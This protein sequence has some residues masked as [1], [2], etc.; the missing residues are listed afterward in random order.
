M[1]ADLRL[2]EWKKQ[3]C[4]IEGEGIIVE[5]TTQT[6][7]HG[8]FME[9]E[10]ILNGTTN[11]V[12]QVVIRPLIR[13]KCWVGARA[14]NKFF[15]ASFDL[16]NGST[17][18]AGE[19]VT[20]HSIINNEDGTFE[21]RVLFEGNFPVENPAFG[22]GALLS[23]QAEDYDGQAGVQAI[24]VLAFHF[25]E[26]TAFLPNLG[27]NQ[28][29]DVF[30]FVRTG[31]APLVLSN[32][33]YET[34]AFT[35]S[36][37]IKKAA[38]TD[39]ETTLLQHWRE[40]D[41][42]RAWRL[43]LNASGHPSIALSDDGASIVKH[44]ASKIPLPADE[45]CLISFSWSGDKLR[46]FIN[47]IELEQDQ[48]QSIV[49]L[50]FE[51]K[52]HASAAPVEAI[53]SENGASF[54][55]WL[56]SDLREP[57]A[58]AS[59]A[60]SLGLTGIPGAIQIDTPTGIKPGVVNNPGNFPT[61]LDAM[62][63]WLEEKGVAATDIRYVDNA[64]G[65]D[66]NNGKSIDSAWRS[67]QQAADNLV[68][69]MAVIIRGRD[70]RFFEQV[71]P[72]T[73]GNSTK[74]IWFVGDPEHP[75]VLDSSVLFDTQWTDMGGNRWRALYD[76]ERKYSKELAYHKNCSGGS[77]RHESVWMSHQ[78]IF[79]DRQLRRISADRV[80]DQLNTGECHFEKGTGSYDKPQ[81]VWCRLP[82][83]S[84]P[85]QTSMRI[86]SA[87]KYLFDWSPH[88]W[89]GSPG[90]TDGEQVIGR[91]YLGLVNLHFRFGA[92]IRKVG[93]LNI[94]GKGWHVEH[95]SIS[96]SNTYGF[97]IAGENHTMIDCKVINSG[98]GIFRAAYLQKGDGE[99]RF[100]RCLFEGGNI[101][102]YPE[103]WEAGQKFTFCGTG[104]VTKFIECMF[105]DIHGPAL[106][107]DL[108][109]G[110]KN[111][112]TPS[113]LIQR[114]IFEKCARNAIFF[115][116]N[117]YNIVVE[118]SGIWKTQESTEGAYGQTLGAAFRSQGAGLNTVRNNAIVLNEGKGLYFKAHD[119]RG[120]NNR[121]TIVDNVLVNNAGNHNIELRRCELYGGD[122]PNGGYKWQ[123]SKI[124]GNV[125]CSQ[126]STTLF[127]RDNKTDV[128]ETRD[129]N[130]FQSDS[131]TNGTGNSL[132]S[133]PQEVVADPENRKT[134]WKT[135][136][137][138]TGKGPQNLVHFE[139]LPGTG[140][141]APQ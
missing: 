27:K 111:K 10:H 55:H 47:D 96:E 139:D 40:A 25:D 33:E 49:D 121:D 86:G 36:C 42:E 93:P 51:G 79:D 60:Q 126:T 124:H 41:D 100:E 39:A 62:V 88:N 34:D 130:T 114:C 28:P 140:W 85:N 68:A 102:R 65:N 70:G 13:T 21:C 8:V 29:E 131:W 45:Q 101:H 56:W 38:D 1:Q 6:E 57:E 20:S 123:T 103:A 135:V 11:A 141:Q 16:A 66:N 109:N 31:P 18:S 95:C 24:E 105:K 61:T 73:S 137:A 3:N 136:G 78:L 46:F 48:I 5:D 129:P 50:D 120:D 84:N 112:S 30:Y 67:I 22:I 75:P 76:K 133:T 23:D 90:G 80:P 37:A 107:W 119:T 14:N 128:I 71:T 113:Y 2:P 32:V 7:P 59:D 138:H 58:I 98:Q 17:L 35:A 53:P 132:A 117:S 127:V 77:C 26:G 110:N 4:T 122:E 54:K 97:S 69:G 91:D 9:L 44:Y 115:E 64:N 99:T 15:M 63:Q 92:T 87:K 81:F 43:F 12:L 118:H 108:F 116:H 82:D 19:N 104:G 106:W 125:F 94:R 134:F 89:E 52:L 83:D 72:K 74:R